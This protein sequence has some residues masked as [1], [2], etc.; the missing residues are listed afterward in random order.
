MSW[1][2]V[3]FIPRICHLYQVFVIKYNTAKD[4]DYGTHTNSPLVS[5][6]VYIRKKTALQR[7]HFWA[8]CYPENKVSHSEQWHN[9][10]SYTFMPCGH[11]FSLQ[12]P[13]HQAPV[14]LS[15]LQNASVPPPRSYT[16]ARAPV[17]HL[18]CTLTTER[19]QGSH[20]ACGPDGPWPHPLSRQN[21][22]DS[23]KITLQFCLHQKHW[24]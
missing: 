10:V 19:P 9:P 8:L 17:Q 21:C 2:G 15:H 13:L 12:Q 1:N 7:K 4:K 3:P 16:W 20:T 22:T 6:V 5:R 23:I 24:L 14:Y 18:A 11:T